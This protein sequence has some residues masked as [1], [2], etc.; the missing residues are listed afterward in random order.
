M[1]ANDRNRGCAS[2]AG[3]DVI[4]ERSMAQKKAHEVDGWIA[5][6][7]PKIPLVLLYGPDRGLVS[8]RGRALAEKSGIALNDPFSV[9]KL[10]ASAAEGEAGRILDEAGTI[11]MFAARR[12]LWIRNAGNQKWLVDDLATLAARPPVDTLVLVEGGDLKKGA[13]LRTVFEER[14]SAMALP[15]YADEVK[16]LD[17]VIDDELRRSGQTMSAEARQA[18]RDRLGGDRLASRGEVEKLAL[19]ASPASEITLKDVLAIV[20]DVSGTSHDEMV[21]CVLSGDRAGFVQLF[22]RNVTA[23]AQVQPLLAAATRQFQMLQSL[24]ANMDGA[25]ASAMASSVRPPLHGARRTSLERALSQWNLPA[26]SQAL[27]NLQQAILESRRRSDLALA[28]AERALLL[29]ASKVR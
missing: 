1:A 9:T 8:E 19:Y 5:R 27:E 22:T 15:C 17:Q 28:I 24:R 26:L 20:G 10:D 13:A 25:S 16:G 18:L 23:S 3:A 6:P 12:L 4:A 29:I 14:A 11:S 2:R 7:D 21:E